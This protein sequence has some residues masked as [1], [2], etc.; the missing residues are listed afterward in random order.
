MANNS[1]AEIIT[2]QF[3]GYSNFIGTHWWNCQEAS[4]DYSPDSISDINH[5]IL[6]REGLNHMKEIITFTPR[7]LLVDLKGSVGHLVNDLYETGYNESDALN[8]ISTWP[9]DKV[10]KVN[11]QPETQNTN[12]FQKDLKKLD[13]GDEEVARELDCKNYQLEE[14][15]K[16]W[17]DFMR[18]RYHPKSFNLIQEYQHENSSQPFDCYLQGG[19]VWKSELMTEDWTDK[20]RSFVEEC[21]CLQ[22]FQIL[23]DATG[24]FG[25]LCASSLQ[26]LKDEY[27]TKS[28]LVFPVIPP[29]TL[30]SNFKLRNVNTA[31]FFASLSELSDVFSP[32][33]ISS[34]CWNQTETY[35]KFPYME[36]NPSLLYHSSAI[37]SS[38]L[39]SVSLSY[40]L[41]GSGLRLNDLCSLLTPVGRKA[42]TSSI[43][44]PWSMKHRQSL[45]ECLEQ[46]EGPLTQSLTP[47]SDLQNV[48]MQVL[49]LRGVDSQK[50]FPKDMNN[51]DRSSNPAYSCSSPHD[52][53]QY[54]LSCD[55]PRTAHRVYSSSQ[56]IKTV[57]PFPDVF[58][59]PVSPHGCVN[60]TLDDIKQRVKHVPVLGGLHC[61]QSSGTMLSDLH[62]AVKKVN[63]KSLPAFLSLDKTDY[64]ETLEAV[65][66]LSDNYQENH[67]M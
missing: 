29:Q 6:F 62:A 14:S 54:Y 18:T 30:E 49:N 26:H 17:S 43:A 20:V 25:G 57:N 53:L 37:I 46:W 67:D 56:P 24:G 13:Y 61:C 11:I 12:D 35:R 27:S 10:E 5:D 65:I 64:D 40:R 60:E 23:S 55:M 21:D 38:L 15:V 52:L 4:F 19:E 48:A 7:M 47:H 33:S 59:K 41:R 44:L 45:L 8:S 63:I 16:Y 31:L 34:D 36:Y 50:M 39:D 66:S 28:C 32:L 1:G 51:R 58:L 42:T 9:P 3:G 2:L 22:G